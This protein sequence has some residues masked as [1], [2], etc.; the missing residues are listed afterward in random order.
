MST[1][2]KLVE[3]EIYEL[4]P[5]APNVQQNPGGNGHN[6]NGDGNSMDNLLGERDPHLWGARKHRHVPS[7]VDCGRLDALSKSGSCVG[8]H[9][10][11]IY[12]LKE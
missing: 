11:K 2:V 9:F 8:E 3:L 12:A 10:C 5:V 6:S 7:G 4:T 1:K